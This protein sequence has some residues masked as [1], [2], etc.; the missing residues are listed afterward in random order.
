MVYTRG[1]ITKWS[2]LGGALG[3]VS[4]FLPEGPFKLAALSLA[5]VALLPRLVCRV[6]PGES[7]S[8]LSARWHVLLPRCVPRSFLISTQTSQHGL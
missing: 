5:F 6:K 2:R 3:V 1:S 8:Y 7:T 4:I